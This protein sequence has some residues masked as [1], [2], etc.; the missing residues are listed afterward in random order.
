MAVAHV[1][2][3]WNGLAVNGQ[4]FTRWIN[5][6]E[7]D[8]PVPTVFYFRSRRRAV[9]ELLHRPSEH[10]WCN[11]WWISSW[12]AESLATRTNTAAE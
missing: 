1:G 9:G 4:F 5:D 12:F 2:I 11:V 6:F 3:K 7:A 10:G 8:G